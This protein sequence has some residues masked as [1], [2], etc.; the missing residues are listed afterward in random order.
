MNAGGSLYDGAREDISWNSDTIVKANLGR[1][2]WTLEIAVPWASLKAQ[3]KAGKVVGFNVCRD[4]NLGDKEWTNWA[5]TITGFH[6]P[7]RFAHLVLSGT[8]DQ[9]GKLAA[10][11]RKGDR[12][13]PV[14]IFS[15]EGFSKNTY[16]ELASATFTEVGKLLVDLEAECA[17]EKDPATATE[18]RKWVDG[19]QQRVGEFRARSQGLMDAASWV[20]LDVDVQKLVPDRKRAVVE[21]PLS[22]LP[23]GMALAGRIKELRSDLPC[24]LYGGEA[25][26]G[27]ADDELRG[28][29]DKHPEQEYSEK[30]HVERFSSAG[31][32]FSTRPPVECHGADAGLAPPHL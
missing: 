10:E 19:Y 6:D 8:P 5:R 20:R 25:P 9:I 27:P 22:A 11:L 24:V 18:L 4:R 15:S 21:A 3:P 26:C 14:A 30:Q 16:A 17:R 1:N 2:A 32:R 31:R 12:S 29:A 13:G 28:S 7:A 23:A